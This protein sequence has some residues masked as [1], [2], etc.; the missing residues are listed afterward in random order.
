MSFECLLCAILFA[1]V[2]CIRPNFFV[3]F[4]NLSFTALYARNRVTQV[5]VLTPM[6]CLMLLWVHPNVFHFLSLQHPVRV[7]FAIHVISFFA[8]LASRF[9]IPVN[10][11]YP[12]SL[13]EWRSTKCLSLSIAIICLLPHNFS[14]MA[15]TPLAWGDAGKR[16]TSKER[17]F[18]S[19]SVTE[20][21]C[22]MS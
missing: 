17:E 11:N 19:P 7:L 14:L 4:C 21:Q 13:L 12:R 20:G 3:E 15:S 6:R 9:S 5:A 18:L 8:Q 16:L 10:Y 2:R 22:A 1:L